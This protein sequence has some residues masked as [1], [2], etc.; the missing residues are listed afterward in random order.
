MAGIV[1]AC[2]VVAAALG[3]LVLAAVQMHPLPHRYLAAGLPAALLLLHI[4]YQLLFFTWSEST[5]GMRYARIGFC[6]FNDDNPSR[7]AMRRRILASILS[8]APLGLGYLW[9]I[10][11]EDGL[12]WHD[13]ISRI[14]QR[15]Y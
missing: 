3:F 2:L 14:Y 5:P 11:D 4:L 13:R 10:L 15:S 12:G 9:A 7:S 8:A 6:T 1:D